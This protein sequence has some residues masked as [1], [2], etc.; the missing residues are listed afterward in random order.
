M[1][2]PARGPIIVVMVTPA[3]RS[4]FVVI[5]TA[6][7]GV[8]VGLLI[9]LG[10]QDLPRGGV[11]LRVDPVVQLDAVSQQSVLAV[12]VN[13]SDVRSSLRLQRDLLRLNEIDGR[14]QE[15]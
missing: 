11:D 6:A 12:E 5:V 3:R 4:V 1:V 13:L 10:A 14:L 8:I 7:K 15:G 9:V 2:T